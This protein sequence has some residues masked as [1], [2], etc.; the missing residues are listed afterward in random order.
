MVLRG[1]LWT[2]VPR[3]QRSL[4]TP[5]LPLGDAWS[6][7]VADPV[8]GDVR[9]SGVLHVPEGAR[10]VVVLVHGLGGSADS[11][12]V[13]IAAAAAARSG[14][15]SLR[16][17]LRGADG[18]G[19]DYYHA[20]LTDDLTA[21]LQCSDLAR[22]ERLYLLGY[23]LGG[24]VALRLAATVE[25]PRLTAVAAICAPLD[26]RRTSEIIDR[27]L[28]A[29]PY[30]I[31]LLS[32]LKLIYAAVAAR[33]AVPEPVE[34]VQ[35]IRRMRDWDDRVVAPRFGFG[36]ALDYYT[37]MSVG[38]LLGDLRVP[39]LMIS[40]LHDPMVPAETVAPWLGRVPEA[41]TVRW[42]DEGGH[43]GFPEGVDL[44]LGLA[45]GGRSFESQIL[46]WLRRK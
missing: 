21:A 27:R 6:C 16:L 22:F 28:A 39:T 19:E 46:T 30:R 2:L 14:M 41:L 23:S 33:R 7:V 32:A 25:T 1:H 20:G 38:P 13:R 37:R 40:T 5:R 8:A 29:A 35:K 24:H 43:L 15:A 44:G 3:L 4:R 11:D 12:Y 17:N 26:L 42:I 18:L 34:R 10:E 45:G 9:L 31:Y 36:D